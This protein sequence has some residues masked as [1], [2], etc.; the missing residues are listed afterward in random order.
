MSNEQQGPGGIYV[1]LDIAGDEK[2]YAYV[3]KADDFSQ[4]FGVHLADMYNGSKGKRSDENMNLRNHFDAEHELVFMPAFELNV[5][6][7]GPYEKFCMD[8][9]EEYGFTLDNINRG[10]YVLAEEVREKCKAELEEGFQLRFETTP[11]FMA[12]ASLDERKKMLEK[13]AD[14][15]LEMGNRKWLET[16]KWDRF[17]FSKER[18]GEKILIN[19]ETKNNGCPE[20]R[21]C[22]DADEKDAFCIGDQRLVFFSKAGNYIGDGIDQILRYESQTIADYGF[23]LWT[24]AYNA[25][26]VDTVLPVCKSYAR[27]DGEIY[28]IFTLTYSDQYAARPSDRFPYIQPDDVQKIQSLFQEEELDG[29]FSKLEKAGQTY[30]AP[31]NMNTTASKGNKCKAFVIKELCPLKET[32]TTESFGEN[33]KVLEKPLKMY[34]EGKWVLDEVL[35][36]GDIDKVNQKG[37][38][39]LW[40]REVDIPLSD[41][42]DENPGRTMS[43]LAK[44]APPYVVVLSKEGPLK[45]E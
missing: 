24:F 29:F 1:I 31:K 14:K 42:V 11:G 3:G 41:C 23:C 9:M 44:L 12:K 39:C 32:F 5:S 21:I 8:L 34:A 16:I 45:E 4:R 22:Q 30:R 36:Q 19:L 43:F 38:F 40:K 35:Q 25:V 7:L 6:D 17:I 2:P 33:Y 26:P 15:R 13:Y 28:A 37:T 27:T 10:K 18:I 20:Y